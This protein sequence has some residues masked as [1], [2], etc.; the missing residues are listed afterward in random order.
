[1]AVLMVASNECGGCGD[2]IQIKDEYD[3]TIRSTLKGFFIVEPSKGLY[4]DC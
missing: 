2:A 3:L 4:T 1:M